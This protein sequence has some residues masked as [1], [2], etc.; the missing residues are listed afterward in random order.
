[1]RGLFLSYS[2]IHFLVDFFVMGFAIS[3]RNTGI[4][5]SILITILYNA[6]VFGLELPLGILVNR[7]DKRSLLAGAGCLIVVPG[8]FLGSYCNICYIVGMLIACLG[9]SLF[10]VSCG[11]HIL[12][13]KE[14]KGFDLG[15]FISAGA[16]AVYLG[17]QFGA[18]GISAVGMW[19]MLASGIYLMV[20]P[21]P[22]QVTT[23]ERPKAEG[24]ELIIFGCVMLFLVKGFLDLMSVFS[25]KADFSWGLA[26]AVAIFAGQFV[27]AVLIDKFGLRKTGLTGTLIACILSV[28]AGF[29]PVLGIIMF[30]FMVFMMPVGI[31]SL[32]RYING[33]MAFGLVKCM[34]FLGCMVF[35]FIGGNNSIVFSV[36]SGLMVPLVYLSTRE[37]PNKNF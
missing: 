5:D 31:M 13:K 22:Y 16:V 12:D 6:I 10:H 19:I 9:S 18:F 32:N 26:C 4:T 27:G 1:M 23:T 28:F 34:I 25:W 37:S 15:M 30:F 8:I 20:V 29:V 24:T 14:S 21:F 33:S 36:L 2:I 11:S 3:V 17:Q 35:I 7:F